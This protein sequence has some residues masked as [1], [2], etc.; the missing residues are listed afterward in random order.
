MLQMSPANVPH[1]YFAFELVINEFYCIYIVRL[2]RLLKRLRVVGNK[3]IS[4]ELNNEPIDFYNTVTNSDS[5]SIENI[6][7]NAVR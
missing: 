5:H 6:V 1:M 4:E 3:F 2:I 7:S